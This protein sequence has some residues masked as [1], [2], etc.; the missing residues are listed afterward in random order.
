M[1]QPSE[2]GADPGVDSLTSGVISGRFLPVP[3]AG[4]SG[5]ELGVKLLQGRSQLIRSAF[6]QAFH[7]Q[8]NVRLT[9]LHPT[10]SLPL[11]HWEKLALAYRKRWGFFTGFYLSNT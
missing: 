3:Q 8:E 2:S 10:S 4:D 5:Q 9:Q 11:P 6:S 1:S 7:E